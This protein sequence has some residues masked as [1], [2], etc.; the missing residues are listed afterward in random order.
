M[1]VLILDPN[2]QRSVPINLT[3]HFQ[4]GE[5]FVRAMMREAQKR[6]VKPR[7]VLNSFST[8]S[9]DVRFFDSTVFFFFS[10]KPQNSAAKQNS[11]K[12]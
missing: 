8:L 4:K 5:V 9:Y 7:E 3:N 11:L 2:C 10:E 6:R 12:R 1:L